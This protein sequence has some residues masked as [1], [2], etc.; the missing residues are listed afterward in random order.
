MIRE[1]FRPQAVKTAAEAKA[2]KAPVAAAAHWLGLGCATAAAAE[3]ETTAAAEGALSA[4]LG[5]G[6]RAQRAAALPSRLY[7]ARCWNQE[8]ATRTRGQL[9][10]V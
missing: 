8:A 4:P 1:V 7:P 3:F 9:A 6:V 10:R 2:A 5:L